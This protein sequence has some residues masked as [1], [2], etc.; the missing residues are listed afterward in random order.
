MKVKLLSFGAV[1]NKHVQ[2]QISEYERRLKYHKVRFDIQ[3]FNDSTMK[4]QQDR[5]LTYTREHPEETVILLDE[6]GTTTSSRAFSEMLDKKWKQGSTVT[7]ILGDAHGFDEEFKKG[8][9]QRLSLSP[10]TFPHE[11]AMLLWIEQVYRAVCIQ[12]NRPY[13]KE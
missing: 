1:K 8:F 7:F 4:T 9:S 12:N 5:I 11:I 2:A 10:M 13:H 6:H 3:R